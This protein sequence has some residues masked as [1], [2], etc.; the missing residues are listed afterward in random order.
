MIFRE[1]LLLATSWPSRRGVKRRFLEAATTILLFGSLS[2]REELFSGGVR[3]VKELQERGY[4]IADSPDPIRVYPILDGTRGAAHHGGGWIPGV[5]KLRPDPVDGISPHIYL[6]HELMH[7]ANHRTCREPL[8]RWAEEASALAFSGEVEAGEALPSEESINALRAKI[9]RDA[10]LD[11][12][13]YRTLRQIVS[14]F[15]WPESPCRVTPEIERILA[16]SSV[17]RVPLSSIVISVASGRVLESTGDIQRRDPPGSLLKVLYAASLDGVPE[18][19]LADALLKS[20]TRRLISW[21]QR[22]NR[23]RLSFF[24]PRIDGAAPSNILLGERDTRGEYPIALSLKEL[25]LFLRAALLSAPHRFSPLS[26]NGSV[27]GSTLKS[28]ATAGLARLRELN[29]LAKTGTVST[30]EGNPLLGH[31]L[32]AWPAKAPEYLAVIKSGGLRGRGV[33][34]QAAPF[35]KRWGGDYPA[36]KGLVRVRLLSLLSRSD[37]Q[38][39]GECPVLSIP[40]EEGAQMISLCGEFLVKT[41]AHGAKPERYV[42]GFLEDSSRSIILSTDPESYADGVMEAE[43]DSLTGEAAKALRAIIVWDGL[44]GAHRHTAEDAL[45][46]STHCMVFKGVPEKRR[47]AERTSTSRELLTIL[48]QISKRSHLDWLP[49]SLGGGEPWRRAISGQALA[50]IVREET[51]LE[52]TRHR[53]PHGKVTI[54]LH[55]GDSGET[56]P[57]DLIRKKLQLPSCPESIIPLPDGWEFRGTGRGHGMGFDILH[58]R[59]QAAE[60]KLAPELLHGAYDLEWKAPDTKG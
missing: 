4:V 50:S 59:E 36:R 47:R 41:E 38:V 56:L 57:C 31:L 51:V 52:V 2:G 13:P 53:D 21:E 6:R 46:D 24:Y 29:A 16:T 17:E 10:P 34:A 7:E 23:E 20:D 49:F 42:R 37:I 5:I 28:G 40:R 12:A 58:A 45:C 15:G 9:E 19:E 18:N 44:H 1:I 26:E 3:A 35:L 43:A 30:P 54:D 55:Y 32:I 27:D 33:L 60:G 8:P 48:D 11:G 14:H 39:K 25:S 22:L